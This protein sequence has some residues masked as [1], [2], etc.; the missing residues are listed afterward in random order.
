M[1]GTKKSKEIE[2]TYETLKSESSFILF[3]YNS[4]VEVKLSEKI[5]FNKRKRNPD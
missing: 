3:V 4:P 1:R 2:F 5:L